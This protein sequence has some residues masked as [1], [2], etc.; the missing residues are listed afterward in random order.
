MKDYDLDRFRYAK[1]IIYVQI[2]KIMI[3][4]DSDMLKILYMFRY[5]ICSDMKDYDLDRFRYER[6]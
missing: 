6:L 4:T 5:K 2:W 1:D 3:S